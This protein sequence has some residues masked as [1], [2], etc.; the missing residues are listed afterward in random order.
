MT[1]INSVSSVFTL[2]P[3]FLSFYKG[4]NF[5]DFLFG[6]F[7]SKSLSKWGLLLKDS[8]SY[9]NTFFQVAPTLF[10]MEEEGNNENDSFPPKHVPV[11]LRNK[12]E[13]LAIQ[14]GYNK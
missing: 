10:S 11:H 3:C 6:L 13:S 1:D 12:A 4:N 9:L 8:I 5:P 2:P 7:D 14:S